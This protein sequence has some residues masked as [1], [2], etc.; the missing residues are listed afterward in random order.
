MTP[1]TIISLLSWDS[2]TYLRNLL[3]NLDAYPPGRSYYHLHILDQG[4]QPETL[5]ILERFAAGKSYVSVE[6]LPENIGYG[7]GHNQS[8]RTMSR[9]GSFDYFLTINN[10]LVFGEPGWLDLL[11]EGMERAPGAAIGGPMCHKNRPGMLS[12]ATREEMRAGDFLFVTGAVA[13]IRNA[14]IR[15]YGLFDEAYAPAYWE[16]ADLAMRYRHFGFGQTYID[17]PVLHGYLGAI[18][19]V[20]VAKNGQ[21]ET[22]WGDFKTLNQELFARRWGLKADPLPTGEGDLRA[23]F[24]K[25]YVPD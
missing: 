3:A 13:M 23:C 17:I 6:Y 2:P 16:D 25:L 20:N 4:S 19:R 8:H 10:D 11:V 1:I 9:A 24:P 18:D 7:P 14:A 22:R 5:E 12:P 15:R 21:L